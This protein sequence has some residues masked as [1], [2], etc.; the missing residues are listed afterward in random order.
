MCCSVVLVEL[1]K[2]CILVQDCEANL[3]NPM[4]FIYDNGTMIWT[5]GAPQCVG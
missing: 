5:L 3:G 2:M 1:G 4:A